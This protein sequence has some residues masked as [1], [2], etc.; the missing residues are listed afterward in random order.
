VSRSRALT[1]AL[2]IALA[3]TAVAMLAGQGSGATPKTTRAITQTAQKSAQ[4]SAPVK[5]RTDAWPLHHGQSA[6]TS[7]RGVRVA[8]LQYLLR[9][10][11][12][13]EN[14]YDKVKGTLK[15]RTF[16]RGIFDA[17]TA[18]A[19][20]AYKYR[21]GYPA[22]GQC[23]SSRNQWDRAEVTPFFF[24]L[25][26][27]KLERPTCWVAVAAVR[28]KSL[29]AGATDNALKLKAVE[30]SQLG[31]YGG[32]RYTSYFNLPSYLAW[33][34]I[35]Q[36]WGLVHAG[37][38]TLAAFGAAN[39]WYVPSIIQMGHDHGWLNAKAKVGAFVAFYG[40]ISHIGYVVKVLASG[41]VSIEGN[42]GGRVAEVYHP[43]ND[44][45][46]YFVW[47]PKL[48]ADRTP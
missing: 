37:L 35:F 15:P 24:S 25:L 9:D 16:T 41:Y 33:C 3:L 7:S 40:D 32:Y 11:R 12:P 31:V 27:G 10:P 48:T 2:W 36:N 17:P 23:S 28:L 19:V 4:K 13:K 30:L 42:W 8:T 20:V 1:A 43:W 47:V 21:L 29:E 38:P 26:E 34:A 5:R 18:K 44:H 39:P 22:R 46:R 6:A 45:L 14:V